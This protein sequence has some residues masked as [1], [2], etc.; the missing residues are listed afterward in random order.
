MAA[1]TEPTEHKARKAHCCEWCGERIEIGEQ[2]K[3]YRYFDGGDAGTVKLHS[4][5]FDAM[6]DYV[7]K[8]GGWAEWEPGEFERPKA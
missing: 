6:Q 2:Y 8:Q 4:E 3:R 1:T 7:R 5:C